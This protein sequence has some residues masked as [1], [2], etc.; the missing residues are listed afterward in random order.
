MNC[1]YPIFIPTPPAIPLIFLS[2]SPLFPLP[3]FHFP[4]IFPPNPVTL[5]PSFTAK[6]IMIFVLAIKTLPVNQRLLTSS[7]LPFSFINH[8]N[9]K[10]EGG[11][12]QLNLIV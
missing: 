12:V 9:R 7:S 6:S 10:R 2:T 1:L 8:P 11:S 5:L 3:L 4:H